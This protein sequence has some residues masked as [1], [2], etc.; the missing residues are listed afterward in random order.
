[1]EAWDVANLIGLAGI[2]VFFGILLWVIGRRGGV[3]L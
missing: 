1:M 3:Q 2:A